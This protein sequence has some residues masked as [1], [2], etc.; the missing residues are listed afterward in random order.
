MLDKSLTFRAAKIYSEEILRWL[1][2]NKCHM[3]C[4]TI[5]RIERCNEY[6]AGWIIK[7]YDEEDKWTEECRSERDDSDDDE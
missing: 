5:D 2:L 4:K 1:V 3:S 6:F 7:Y